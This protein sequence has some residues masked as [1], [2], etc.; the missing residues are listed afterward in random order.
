MMFGL[1]VILAIIFILPFV[2]TK[3]EKNLEIFLFIMGILAAAVSGIFSLEFIK[4]ILL[5]D[6]LYF[7]SGAVLLAGLVFKYTAKY[8][9]AGVNI[10][11][12]R[13]PTFIFVFTLIVLIGLISSAITAIVASLILVEIV[14]VLPYTR[15]AKVNLMIISCFSI[16]LGAALT[17]IGE[18]LSTI[19]VSA[20]N[21]DFFY[22][23]NLLGAYIVPG[24]ISL[25][26]FGGL[27][28]T[29]SMKKYNANGTTD[30]EVNRDIY[31]EGIKEVLIRTVKIFIFI[32]GLELLGTGFNPLIDTYVLGLSNKILYWLNICA[33]ALDNA[34]VAAAMI[35]P[36]MAAAQVKSILMGLLIS[37][38]MLIP[39]NISNIVVAENFDIKSR[40]WAKLGMPLGLALLVIYYVVLFVI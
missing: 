30:L 32:L 31:E 27:Y 17:P 15:R 18:P 5:N 4:E 39:G 2:I 40:E 38:G 28:V 34:T 26:I 9:S 1:L 14:A 24:I 6:M 37:G 16:G 11:V 22:L 25:G 33:A 21:E 3:V 19:V 12:E 35:S 20:L 10:I 29:K 36:S 13:V 7:V 8:I 23:L